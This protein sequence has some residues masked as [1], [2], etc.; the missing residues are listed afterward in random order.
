MQEK[1]SC[2]ESNFDEIRA[3]KSEIRPIE[4]SAKIRPI[5][6]NSIFEI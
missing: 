5:R 6:P 4:N 3:L 1:K 2:S